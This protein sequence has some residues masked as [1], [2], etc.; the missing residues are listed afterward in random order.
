MRSRHSCVAP[1]FGGAAAAA[2]L[3][4]RAR[5]EP[6]HANR[7]ERKVEHE[8]GAVLEHAGA[9]QNSNPI[10]KPHSAVPNPG[11]RH[12]HLEDA[13]GRVVADDGDRRKQA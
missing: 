11:L 8:G 9:G 13:D 1:S 12:A 7:V 6:V 4:R 2:V 10:A 5:L 3:H